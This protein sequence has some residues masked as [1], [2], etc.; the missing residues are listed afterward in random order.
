MFLNCNNF[1][2]YGS[3]GKDG[4]ETTAARSKPLP[5][6]K[7]CCKIFPLKQALFKI[8]FVAKC[9]IVFQA[10]QSFNLQSV[11]EWSYFLS[12]PRGP[13]HPGQIPRTFQGP[14]LKN[15]EKQTFEGGH[16]LFGPHPSRQSSG[17]KSYRAQKLNFV[18]FFL[19]SAAYDTLWRG[20]LFQIELSG[21][22]EGM[23]LARVLPHDKSG[24][25]WVQRSLGRKGRE[26]FGTNT[27]WGCANAR[28]VL[29]GAK[30]VGRL[31][32]LGPKAR[33]FL[34]PWFAKP[35][36]CMRVAF[37]ENDG[38]HENNE[39]DEDNSDN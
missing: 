39:D 15:Q 38:N 27:H 21:Q 29:D 7:P 24:K 19:S 31:L 23:I 9:C 33:A 11:A 30:T 16:A 6:S 26:A 10:L 28:R 1:G 13:G 22:P 17:P 8:F 35:M 5:P 12:T 34:N 4:L 25:K 32:L 37:H 18:L 2:Y 3:V 14:S 36:V 20:P